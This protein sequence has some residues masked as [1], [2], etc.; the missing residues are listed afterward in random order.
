MHFLNEM[1]HVKLPVLVSGKCLWHLHH[2]P[3]RHLLVSI[4]VIG[5]RLE[6][7]H[8]GAFKVRLLTLLPLR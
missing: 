8:Q 2:H 1:L 7:R 5:V 6:L 4:S 3:L